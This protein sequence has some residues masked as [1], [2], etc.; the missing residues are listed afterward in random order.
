MVTTRIA[1]SV[2]HVGL[3]TAALLLVP[4]VAMQFTTEVAWGPGD[5]AAAAA[6]LFGAGLL[7]VLGCRRAKSTHQRV[8]AGLI[9]FGAL[10]IDW[11]ELAV[12]VFT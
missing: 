6:L 8:A 9:I 12:G 7:Y 5:F 10:T 11:A 1:Q 4:S 2:L 3:V